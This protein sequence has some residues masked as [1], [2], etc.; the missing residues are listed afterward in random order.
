MKILLISETSILANWRLAQKP[1]ASTEFFVDEGE[2]SRGDAD[3]NE[4]RDR[5]PDSV[6]FGEFPD[7][8][9]AEHGARDQRN[10]DNDER[11]PPD[12]LWVDNSAGFGFQFYDNIRVISRHHFSSISNSEC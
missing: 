9:D 10:G 12:E 8:E 4:S 11:D 5:T 2:Y 1:A 3:D 7:R 6:R